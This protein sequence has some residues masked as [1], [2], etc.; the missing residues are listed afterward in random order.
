M[1]FWLTGNVG[2]SS[3]EADLNLGLLQRHAA[4]AQLLCLSWQLAHGLLRFGYGSFPRSVCRCC[5][6]YADLAAHVFVQGART[7]KAELLLR[8]AAARRSLVV[9]LRQKLA[10]SHP[11]I[12]GRSV[13]TW[14][15]TPNST[16]PRILSTQD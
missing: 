15:F 14:I 9:R 8:L 6:E 10:V 5:P 3:C 16:S 13:E 2:R 11:I 4:P 7:C 1:S 12:D